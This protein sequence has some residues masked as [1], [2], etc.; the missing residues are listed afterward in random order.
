MD[1]V[2]VFTRESE[3]NIYRIKVLSILITGLAATFLLYTFNPADSLFYAPCLFH[4]ITGLYCP[5][6]GSLRAMHQLLHMHFS[7]AFKLNPLFVLSIPL[8]VYLLLRSRFFK[9]KKYSSNSDIPAFL[10]WIY[11]YVVALFWIIRNI[12]SYPF[13]LLSP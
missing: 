2:C 12:P 10:I 13:S 9:P 4:A 3:N 1:K 7:A 6:C 5:G 11:L 8:L